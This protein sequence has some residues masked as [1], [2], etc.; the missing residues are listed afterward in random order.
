M[1]HTF[2]VQGMICGHCAGTVRESL[3]TLDPQ[4]EIQIRLE[5][6]CVS[7]RSA[8]PREQLADA[9]REAGYGVE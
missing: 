6:G 7:V 5:D 3:Q 4:A 1:E 2:Q 8:Q 9:I